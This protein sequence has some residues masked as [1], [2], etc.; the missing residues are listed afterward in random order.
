MSPSAPMGSSLIPT[1]TREKDGIAVYGP[2][3]ILDD[4]Q[5]AIRNLMILG[6]DVLIM[7]ASMHLAQPMAMEIGV[8][9]ES[10]L[11]PLC[12]IKY[13]V[14]PSAALLTAVAAAEARRGS[15]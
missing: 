7:W 5:V 4:M 11:D 8:I 3:A 15:V 6:E 2:L 14:G 9:P 10:R 1:W 13:R 12:A